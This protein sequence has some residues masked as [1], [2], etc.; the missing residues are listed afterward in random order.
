LVHVRVIL[1]PFDIFKL[2]PSQ[3]S[4]ELEDI[5]GVYNYSDV[6]QARKVKSLKISKMFRIALTCTKP[7]K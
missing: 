6:Y 7:G 5:K 3:E 1:N 4:E 2:L